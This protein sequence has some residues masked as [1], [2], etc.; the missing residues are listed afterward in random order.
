M[1]LLTIRDLQHRAVRFGVVIVATSLVFALLMLMNGFANQLSNEAAIAVGNLGAKYWITPLGASAPFTSSATLPAQASQEVTQSDAEPILVARSG[2]NVHGQRTEI[3]L[4][5]HSIGGGI[6]TPKLVRGTMPEQA[7]QVAVDATTK[8]QLQDTA[9]IGPH[10]YRVVG[11]FKDETMLAGVPIIFM[12]LTEAQRLVANGNQVI[13]AILLGEPPATVPDGTMLQTAK[14]VGDDAKHPLRKAISSIN[15]I[16]VLL[17]IVA[18]MIV[19]GVIYLSSMERRR[20]F[21]V[22]KAIGADTR[23]LLV[24]LGAQSVIV[25]L[26]ASII[27]SLLQIV[28]QPAFP[29][30]VNVTPVTLIQ[31]VLLSAV[32]ALVAG[33]AGMRQVARVDPALSFAS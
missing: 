13:S 10:D 25:A 1:W 6:G 17:W 11:I 4:I 16:R 19:G 28:L 18:A 20:D 5:G 15:L 12:D 30:K 32:I 31:V 22:L 33:V 23:P 3:F 21:A 26:A 29:M 7:D 14:Q 9:H 8:L 24:G 2:L 27:G